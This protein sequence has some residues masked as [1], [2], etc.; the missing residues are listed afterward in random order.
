MGISARRAR[1]ALKA[2]GLRG[3]A[4]CT[5]FWP[6]ARQKRLLALLH[7]RRAVLEA[8]NNV[9][10][11]LLTTQRA[12]ADLQLRRLEQVQAALGDPEKKRLIMTVGASR[13]MLEEEL[14]ARYG[15]EVGRALE[16]ALS[17][18]VGEGVTL[19]V[20]AK[21]ALTTHDV[22]LIVHGRNRPHYDLG[23]LN[24]LLR[25]GRHHGAELR[26][27]AR[28]EEATGRNRTYRM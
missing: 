6:I 8:K 13:V 27:R 24:R 7:E 18:L 16:Q 10:E 15:S 20:P 9:V 3:P 1:R 12:L 4:L 5:L 26:S 25:E 2:A 21:E 28:R 11:F 14:S 22:Y 17:E 23:E 19:R